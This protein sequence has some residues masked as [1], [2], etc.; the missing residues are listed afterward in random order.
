MCVYARS[1]NTLL[2]NLA[3]LPPSPPPP[4]TAPVSSQELYQCC[5][6]NVVVLRF[7]S[8]YNQ[9]HNKEPLV[10]CCFNETSS[11]PFVCF[12]ERCCK[13]FK[14]CELSFLLELVL[15]IGTIDG[16]MFG[17]L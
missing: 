8:T 16:E 17:E 10:K 11:R 6:F 5:V 7:Y 15:L 4:T 1:Q 13:S 14:A 12:P 2:F 3:P 9:L